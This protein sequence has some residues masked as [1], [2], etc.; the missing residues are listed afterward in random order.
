MAT[1][2]GAATAAEAA[3]ALAIPPSATAQAMTMHVRTPVVITSAPFACNFPLGHCRFAA[4]REKI[5]TLSLV[6]QWRNS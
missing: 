6:K 3:T 4:R 5:P 1:I 2:L